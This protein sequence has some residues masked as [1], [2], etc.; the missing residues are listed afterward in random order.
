MSIR[1]QITGNNL[2]PGT[3]TARVV[4]G[5]R[6]GL[7]AL[8]AK[9]VAR[10]SLSTGDVRSAV[11]ALIEE[12]RGTLSAG[13]TAVIDG[14]ATFTLSLSGSFAT[15][16][17]TISRD[18][19]QL[20]LVVQGDVRLQAAIAAAA[21]YERLVFDTKTP[22]VSSFYNVATSSFDS[23]T[24]GSIVRLQGD[25]LKFDAA[26]PDEGIFLRADASET[27]LAVYST[28]GPR[29]LDALVPPTLNGM[30]QVIVRTR[31]TPN[32]ELREGRLPR[33]ISQV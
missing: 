27:R 1:Y 4:Q 12:V 25:H 5:R 28:I 13:D 6:V 26:K 24:P 30:Q 14:L 9:V 29:Q 8:I 20:N 33:S 17:A 18:S 19:A 31:Y 16:D 22:I 23:Y 2:K 11:T 3:F 32:G 7:D 21:S 15:P 10:T